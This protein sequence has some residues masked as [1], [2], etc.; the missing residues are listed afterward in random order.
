MIFLSKEFFPFFRI[1]YRRIFKRFFEM[2]RHRDIYDCP[3][4]SLENSRKFSHC[5]FV[6]YNM[7]QHM[8]AI[9]YIK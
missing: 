9:N 7:L 3:S 6:L 2:L 8:T 4:I 1:N 5:F